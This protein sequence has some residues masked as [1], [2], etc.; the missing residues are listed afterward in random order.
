MIASQTQTRRHGTEWGLS[1]RTLAIA[2]LAS[3]TA[4][5]AVS[6]FSRIGTP[7]AA[8]MTPI[9][10]AFVSELLHRPTEKIAGR[11]A[12]QSAAMVPGAA[13]AGPAP[14]EEEEE[15]RLLK[16]AHAEPG[17]EPQ[18]VAPDRPGA[19]GPVRVYRNPA[20]GRRIA[21]GVVVA[22]GALAFVI[23]AIVLTV[24]ELLAGGSIAGGDRPT[25]IGGGTNTSP[26]RE[27]QQPAVTYPRSTET[28]TTTTDQPKQ[29]EPPAEKQPTGTAPQ[30]SKTQPA[31]GNTQ[32]AP[33]TPSPPPP[34]QPPP[35]TPAP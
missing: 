34:Q 27:E 15:E 13:G 22:T 35:E 20:P 28:S 31:T 3:A 32:P 2:S 16:G 14:E 11:F 23:A 21:V 26:A 4:A 29:T 7:I 25:I 30:S 33:S 1:I 17:S 5:I 8:A 12:S 6:Q 9:I 10:V 24:P 19:L 18:P